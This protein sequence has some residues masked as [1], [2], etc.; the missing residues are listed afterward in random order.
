MLERALDKVRFYEVDP[1]APAWV[2]A[3]ETSIPG[4]G[5]NFIS[6]WTCPS[7]DDLWVGNMEAL[8]A[9]DP[10][11]AY[12]DP[13]MFHAD[14]EAYGWIDAR[15]PGNEKRNWRQHYHWTFQSPPT[16]AEILSV[17]SQ[18]APNAVSPELLEEM[19]GPKG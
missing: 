13:L 16:R 11:L 15:H 12:H 2:H 18:L 9:D 3:F 10:S 5:T 17:V 1:P 8:V 7:P 6:V 4:A 19:V 14:D